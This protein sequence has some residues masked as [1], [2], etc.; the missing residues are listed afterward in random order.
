MKIKYITSSKSFAPGKLLP[1]KYVAVQSYRSISIEGEFLLVALIS[2]V[3]LYLS[4]CS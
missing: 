4:G 1:K 3:N 2:A